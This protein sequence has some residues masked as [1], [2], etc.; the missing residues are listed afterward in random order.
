MLLTQLLYITPY[1]S[2]FH[3]SYRY[4]DGILTPCRQNNPSTITILISLDTNWY[5][6]FNP[7]SGPFPYTHIIVHF[8]ADTVTYEEPTIPPELNISRKELSTLQILCIH[9]QNK[10]I[11]TYEQLNQLTHIVSNLSTQQLYTQIATHPP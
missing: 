9:H 3:C 10:Y 1:C 11:G 2:Q 8:A 6:N 4:F 5:Q 7:H